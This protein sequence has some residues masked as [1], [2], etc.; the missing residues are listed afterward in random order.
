M[1]E[2][3]RLGGSKAHRFLV[4]HAS[5]RLEEAAGEQP[6]GPHAI[7]GTTAHYIGERVLTLR[8]PSALDSF[9]GQTIGGVEVTDEMLEAVKVYVDWAENIRAGAKDAKILLEQNVTLAALNP[10]EEMRGSADFVAVIKSLRLLIVG[11]YKHGKGHVVEVKGNKQTR[12][13]ALATLLTLPPEDVVGI[14]KV[15]MTIVQ[16][17]AYHPD[18]PI[19]SEVI[20]IEELLDFAADILAAAEAIQKL[21]AKAVPGDHCLFCAAA[22]NCRAKAEAAVLIAQEEFTVMPAPVT[23]LALVDA[24]ELAGMLKAIE[25]KLEAVEAWVKAARKALHTRL[26]SGEEVPGYKLVAKR[27]TRVWSDLEAT[28]AWA[29]LDA[30]LAEKDIYTTP[31]L[32]SPA[33]M[34][35]LV[36][37]KNLPAK[38]TV[39]VS[40]GYALASEDSNKP[41]ARLSA[42]DEFSIVNP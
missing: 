38:L 20:G 33:Q 31:E 11:D 15:Q 23:D 36:G 4:C 25:P 29:L 40:S 28:K 12:Y 5:P 10:P 41:A 19:R 42:A 30:G 9:R 24:A 32:I 37:K 8:G 13:Y 2:H 6:A 7:E 39:S 34:E 21:D 14:E 3:V 18:G 26:E 1:S 17:R 27:A 16:P 22:G 35:K